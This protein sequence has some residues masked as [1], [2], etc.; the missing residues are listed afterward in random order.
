[1]CIASV[2]NDAFSWTISSTA[3]SQTCAALLMATIAY[4]EWEELLFS[5]DSVAAEGMGEGEGNPPVATHR[6]APRCGAVTVSLR[7][8]QPAGW[9]GQDMGVAGNGT[10]SKIPP[11]LPASRAEPRLFDHD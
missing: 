6:Q 8:R 4:G 7:M 11:A 2:F 3:C 5:G 1:M 9:G 10:W